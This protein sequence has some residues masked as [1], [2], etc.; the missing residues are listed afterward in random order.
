VS[1]QKA[2]FVPREHKIYHRI[3]PYTSSYLTYSGWYDSHKPGTAI[4]QTRWPT[5]YAK[6]W[7]I[8][9]FSNFKESYFLKL[10]S[11]FWNQNNIW[12]E[13]NV[14]NTCVKNTSFLQR[15]WPLNLEALNF[16]FIDPPLHVGI[17]ENI[18]PPSI[19]PPC[20]VLYTRRPSTHADSL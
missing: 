18:I 2:K 12:F 6:E 20:I 19:S 4:T 16:R 1:N 8:T 13:I 5:K 3:T 7:W 11:K 15:M 9:K 17:R 10:W 14:T